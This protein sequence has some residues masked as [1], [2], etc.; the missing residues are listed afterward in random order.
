MTKTRVGGV[1][2]GYVNQKQWLAQGG[3]AEHSIK[4]TGAVTTKP[5]WVTRTWKSIADGTLKEWQVDYLVSINFPMTKEEND[6]R[7]KAFK[8]AKTARNIVVMT[9]EQEEKGTNLRPSQVKIACGGYKRGTCKHVGGCN[10]VAIKKG[11]LC[12]K[13]Y[14]AM[15]AGL[16]P[17]QP[18][19][20]DDGLVLS[21][22][23]AVAVG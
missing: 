2:I 10:K 13:H 23:S 15:V 16:V 1:K 11:G 3:I 9:A 6:R 7:R 12:N 20:K 17:S 14:E 18:A 21:L 8:E 19:N 5:S 22:P 4:T